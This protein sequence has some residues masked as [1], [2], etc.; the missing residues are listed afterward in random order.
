MLM[1]FLDDLHMSH[2]GY[3]YSLLLLEKEN[4]S[5]H[6][7]SFFLD[8]KVLKG[9]IPL[10]SKHCIN[11]LMYTVLHALSE[12]TIIFASSRKEVLKYS[13]RVHPCPP[14]VIDPHT[15]NLGCSVDVR[16]ALHN[17]VL[18]SHFSFLFLFLSFTKYAQIVGN[19]ILPG[20]SACHP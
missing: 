7:F 5:S 15:Q 18:Q 13:W 9:L 11:R 17:V 12:L 2:K 6:F 16:S 10:T 4:V 8:I 3:S 14:C 19:T 1:E 20:F